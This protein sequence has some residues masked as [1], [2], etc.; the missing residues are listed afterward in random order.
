MEWPLPE[1]LKDVKVP[2]F[3][4][5]HVT[6][7]SEASEI[8][9]DFEFKA[10]KKYGKVLGAYDGRPCGE[11]FRPSERRHHHGRYFQ[12]KDHETVF[13]GYYSWWGIYPKYDDLTGDYIKPAEIRKDLDSLD[14]EK[15]LKAF[16]PSYIKSPPESIYGNHAFVSDF[17]HLL[18][19]YAISRDKLEVKKVCI[20]KGA[21][22]RGKLE[23][24]NVCIRKGGTLRYFKEICYV[25]IV[26]IGGDDDEALSD[27]MPL[28][29]DSD[30][31]HTNGLID[32]SGKIVKD[33]AIPTF[34]PKRVM[35]WIKNKDK[36]EPERY[37]YETTAIA[38]YFPDK[39]CNMKLSRNEC[40]QEEVFHNKKFCSKKQ[41][42][43]ESDK[44]KNWK[45]PNESISDDLFNF[46]N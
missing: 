18:N 5:A 44:G 4:L 3:R 43:Q 15:G 7:D 16:V 34:H 21:T 39:C 11:S 19:S 1:I 23:V 37:S 24:K 33:T 10:R 28:E 36:P 31:F 12:I 46:N 9:C 41:P 45:C 27:F 14:H 20:R 29:I 32:D 8:R 25:L 13:P 38:F 17:Q 42:P 35:P 40:T 2:I 22:S 30:Q 6:H 26:C